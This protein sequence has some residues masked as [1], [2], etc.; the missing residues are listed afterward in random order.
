MAGF[1]ALDLHED[2]PLSLW[3]I[4]LSNYYIKDRNHWSGDASI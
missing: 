3:L 2:I 1:L 4:I